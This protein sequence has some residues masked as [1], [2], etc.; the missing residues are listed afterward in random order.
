LNRAEVF[1][2]ALNGLTYEGTQIINPGTYAAGNIII[3]DF[4]NGLAANDALGRFIAQNNLGLGNSE[5]SPFSGDSGGPLII[6]GQVAGVVQGGYGFTGFQNNPDVVPGL[7]GSFGE[8]ARYTRVSNR[9]LWYDQIVPPVASIVSAR[10]LR[11]NVVSYYDVPTGSGEQI[12]NVN[13]VKGTAVRVKFSEVASGAGL[14]QIATAATIR[15]MTGV[16]YTIGNT[17]VDDVNRTIEW[18]LNTT[19]HPNGFWWVD[20]Q[21]KSTPATR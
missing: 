4:D 16:N 14:A 7:N 21:G 10:G 17:T 13:V 20:G 8:L 6:N 18:Q 9:A 12:R 19:V 1:G 2:E 15:G 5:V 11:N 3:Q